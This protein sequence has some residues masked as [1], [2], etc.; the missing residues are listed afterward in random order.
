MCSSD[1]GDMVR[2]D[3]LDEF[4]ERMR[5]AKFDAKAFLPSYG[6]AEA[7]LAVSFAELDRPVEVDTI[8]RLAFKHYGR[9]VAVLGKGSKNQ[10]KVRSFVLCG[11]PLPGHDVMVVDDMGRALGERKVGRILI[12]G[13]SLMAGYLGNEAATGAIMCA[14]GYMDTGDMGYLVKGNIVVTGRAKELILHNGRNIWPQDIEWAVERIELLRSG[15]VA[16]FAIE[17]PQGDEAVVVLVEC[18][19]TARPEMER[20][21]RDAQ[22]AVLRACGIGCEIVLVAPRSLPFTSSGKLARMQAKALFLAGQIGET[23]RGKRAAGQLRV[24]AGH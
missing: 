3:V 1:L 2:L 24:A 23:G 20:L 5:V 14:G 8:D 16:A 17:G 13:P 19:L 4:A 22:A 7:T 10:D 12:K 11:K 15:D 21:R 9:A 6:M 18:R